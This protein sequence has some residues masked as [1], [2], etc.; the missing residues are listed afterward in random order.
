M[1]LEL[2]LD[3][4]RTMINAQQLFNA[5]RDARAALLRDYRGSMRWR[6][7][8]SAE[9]LAHKA[10]GIETSLGKR[11]PELEARAQAF[12]EGRAKARARRD[13]LSARLAQMR[14]INAAYQ[15]GRVP[16]LS[17][18][19]ID[20]IDRAGL[21][22][23]RVRI[24]GTT[25]LYAYEANTGVRFESGLVATDDLDLLLDA[26]AELQIAA[27]DGIDVAAILKPATARAS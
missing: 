26:R 2:N 21:F 24:A 11:S 15:L 14:P 23:G 1:F 5:Y 7:I 19:I 10:D 8:G 3:Q 9:Y 17:A 4:R 18:R 16:E 25:A 22:D 20:A 27:P 6:M 13:S 12:I